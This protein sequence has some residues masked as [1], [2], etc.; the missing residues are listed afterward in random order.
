MS[1]S[2]PALSVSLQKKHTNACTNKGLAIKRHTIFRK[3][4]TLS[5]QMTDGSVGC[6]LH[7]DQHAI[8]LFNCIIL[9][10]LNWRSVHDV[11]TQLGNVTL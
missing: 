2:L 3:M 9:R 11:R 10:F 8:H 6:L 7:I 4:T 1:P 5:G